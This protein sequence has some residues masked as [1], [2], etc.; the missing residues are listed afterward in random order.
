MACSNG[1]PTPRFPGRDGAPSSLQE[2]GNGLLEHRLRLMALLYA[3]RTC[4][5]QILNLSDALG[6]VYTPFSLLALN[7]THEVC[8]R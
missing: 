1:R 5:T 6:R 3:Y 8:Q 2:G 7:L 4:L